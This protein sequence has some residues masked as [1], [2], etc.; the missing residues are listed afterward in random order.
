MHTTSTKVPWADTADKLSQA[1]ALYNKPPTFD[2]DEYLPLLS[3][4]RQCYPF[5]FLQWRLRPSQA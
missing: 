2:A 5:Y 3:Y 1:I 4:R